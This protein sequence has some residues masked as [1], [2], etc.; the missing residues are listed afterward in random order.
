MSFITGPSVQLT[1]I[2]FREGGLR[3]GEMERDSAIAHGGMQFV[4]ERLFLVGTLHAY[5]SK[6]SF[7]N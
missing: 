5:Y 3:F 7:V 6:G 1:I 2:N 4:R